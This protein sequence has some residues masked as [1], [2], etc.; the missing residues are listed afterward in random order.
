MPDAAI[1]AAKAK[2]RQ[3]ARER[4]AGLYEAERIEASRA[5][6]AHA[7]TLLAEPSQTVAGYWA[8]R[9]EV[10]CQPLFVRLSEAGHRI[11]L[12]VITDQTGPLRLRLW[13]P[14][15]P[16]YPSGFGTLAP[17][18]LA[19]E[20]KPDVLLLPLLAFDASGTRLGYGGGHYDRT[21][22]SLSRRPVL[23]GLAFAAQEVGHIPREEHDVPLD[24]VVTEYG[25]T[26]FGKDAA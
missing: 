3:Q 10:D 16:L 7:M 18:E 13:E 1:H 20:V 26:R 25:A 14:D 15:A 11:C 2:L 6:A 24:A 8:L 22:A 9:D 17:S 19:P 5:I 23:V 21:I 12:P 4:R